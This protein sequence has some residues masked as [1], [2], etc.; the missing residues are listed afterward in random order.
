MN[1]NL[2]SMIANKEDLVRGEPGSGTVATQR[3]DTAIKQYRE[4][5]PT[6]AQGLKQSSTQSGGS[7]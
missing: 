7:Q 5:P 4:A 1:S 3:S 6:G 2:A